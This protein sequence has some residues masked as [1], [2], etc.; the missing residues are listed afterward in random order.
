MK[1]LCGTAKGIINPPEDVGDTYLAGYL[2]MMAPK[3]KGVHD[4]LYARVIVL[5][6]GKTKVVL[7]SVE[8]IGLLADFID[9]IKDRLS[10]HG[11][12]YKN[13]YV[14]S[15]HTHAGP[16]TMG[17]WGPII[18]KSGINKKYMYF[19]L[20]TIVRLVL[21]A[22]KELVEVELYFTKSELLDLIENYRARG[23][24][25]GNL[26]VL[27]F[28][29]NDK[30]I[31][32]LWSYS[33]QPEITTREN[34]S[35]SGDYPG[36]VSTMIEQEYGGIS[37]FALG[38][39]GAQSPIY[40]EE[41]Y[42]KM[43]DFADQ[44]FSKI[45]SI[46]QDHKKLNISP[47]EIRF[48]KVK[49]KLENP[50]FQLLYTL[51]I[52]DREYEHQTIESSVSKIRIGELDLIH[53]PGEPFPD[54]IADIVN[55]QE[56]TETICFSNSNDSLGYFIPLNQWSLKPQVWI[57][58]I[59][60]GEFI[61]HETESIGVEAGQVIRSTIRELFLYKTVL[62]IGSHAD[63]LTIWAGGTLTK[64][65][66]E[67]NSLICVRITDDYAD[68]VGLTKEKGIKRNRKETEKAYKAL[69][70]Q[71]VIHMDYPTDSLYTAD[72]H[73][74][75]GKLVRLMRK[76]K[77]DLVVSFDLNGTDE[78]NMD[79]ITT[80]RA[81]NEACWQ[82]SFD[83]FYTEHFD[84]GLEIHAVGE[85]YLFARNPTVLNHFVDI[86]EYIDNKINAINH[87]K[88]VMENWFHQNKLL[89]RANNLYVELLEEDVPNAIRVTLLVKLVY[90]EVG[91]KYGVKYAEEFNK[92]DAGM[93]KD[94][95]ED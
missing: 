78:E 30:L 50:D 36:L 37:L 27:K 2:T 61:G 40:C 64:L 62:A 22:E 47:I 19:L 44:I 33:A 23:S 48:R 39:C 32:S 84:E 71:Q 63:D 92:I 13:V 46:F 16:D 35:L 54:L 66:S 87:Q 24:L 43:E 42:E 82:S 94:L 25:N 59:E 14:F 72:Y 52:L 73:E 5:S 17:L 79:H 9:K 12:P 86:S 28:L 83:L 89:A 53:I 69:G 55:Q 3:I 34:T 57:D 18:G 4:S 81:V 21:G 49:L 7:V 15:T 85:R 58:D 51:G 70:A 77:P 75:R 80:A 8:L 95:A 29:S 65:S 76:Y 56:K 11:F 74:L 1:L 10:A 93:L 41:G 31:A 67:G 90:G 20:D 26:K 45:T 88:T 60:N 6:D 68:C 91:E 38:L